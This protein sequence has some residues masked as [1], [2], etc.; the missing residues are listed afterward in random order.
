MPGIYLPQGDNYKIREKQLEKVCLFFFD[1]HIRKLTRN[2]VP[3]LWYPWENCNILEWDPE[4]CQ[5][6][7][8]W[9][10]EKNSVRM[11]CKTGLIPRN[12]ISEKLLKR[13]IQI[14]APYPCPHFHIISGA[15]L[16]NSGRTSLSAWFVIQHTLKITDL[17][18]QLGLRHFLKA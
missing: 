12:L 4:I 3:L 13:L 8:E 1:S 15:S 9:Q 11:W 2:A 10:S 5:S 7:M 6:I 14:Q 17:I 16:A 18:V